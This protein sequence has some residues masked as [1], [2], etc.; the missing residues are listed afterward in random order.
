M[1]S[2]FRPNGGEGSENDGGVGAYHYISE[3]PG[4][5]IWP[6]SAWHGITQFTLTSIF[7]C[8]NATSRILESI[9]RRTAWNKPIMTLSKNGESARLRLGTNFADVGRYVDFLPA[10]AWPFQH[11]D[12]AHLFPR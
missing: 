3:I 4:A 6:R 12:F 8:N 1:P 2:A 5:G 9:A 10:Q 7:G 11:A